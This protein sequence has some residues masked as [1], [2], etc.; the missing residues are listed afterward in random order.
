MLIARKGYNWNDV[1]SPNW[2]AYNWV[3][4]YKREALYSGFYSI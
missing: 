4:L 2:W 1:L 3:G